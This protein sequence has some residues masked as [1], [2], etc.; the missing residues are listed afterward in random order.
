MDT[1]MIMSG[2]NQFGD[3]IY[4]HNL[5]TGDHYKAPLESIK[6]EKGLVYGFLIHKEDLEK[7]MMM[8]VYDGILKGS[9]GNELGWEAHLFPPN[10]VEEVV[11]GY[12]WPE[13]VDE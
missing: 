9:D 12:C 2:F 4:I 1:K 7:T 5:K 6:V 10:H 3:K 8:Y 11:T 13:Y